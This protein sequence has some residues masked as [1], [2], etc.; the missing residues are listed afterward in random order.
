MVPATAEI[1][2]R[3]F[4]CVIS[5]NLSTMRDHP[6]AVHVVVLL[7]NEGDEIIE[8]DLFDASVIEIE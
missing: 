8:E 7:L 6:T 4:C 2:Q 1:L 3:I 5:G